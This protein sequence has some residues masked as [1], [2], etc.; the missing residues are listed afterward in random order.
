MEGC[1]S[2]RFCEGGLQRDRPCRPPSPLFVG[3]KRC[4]P[5]RDGQP[6]RR[7][8]L[9]AE[10]SRVWTLHNGEGQEHA[11]PFVVLVLNFPVLAGFCTFVLPLVFDVQTLLSEQLTCSDITSRACHQVR[12]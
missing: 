12:E 7:N 4:V 3:P 5:H 6:G 2:G 8:Q 11:V 10:D 1:A 9:K